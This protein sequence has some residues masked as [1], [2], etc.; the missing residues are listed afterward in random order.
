MVILMNEYHR[1]E[2]EMLRE[3]AKGGDGRLEEI[4]RRLS[5]PPQSAY[6]GAALLQQKGLAVLRDT[7]RTRYVLTPRG[8]EALRDGLPEELLVE[9]ICR[10]GE[11]PIGEAIEALGRDLATIAVGQAK[12]QGLLKIQNGILT[13]TE[14]GEE[15]RRERPLRSQLD[16][17][18][19]GGEPRTAE[20]LLKRGLIERSLVTERLASL[21]PEGI[22]AS[23]R[24]VMDDR[25]VDLDPETLRTGAW[26]ER[27]FKPFDVKAPAPAARVAKKQPYRRFLDM[28]RRKLV[29]MGFMEMTGPLVELAFWNF[30][31]LFQAQ[32]HP[33]REIHDTFRIRNPSHGSLPRAGFVEKV[34]MTHEDGWTTGSTGWRYRWSRREASRLVGRTQ[35][36]ALSARTLAGG[37]D[38]P[39]KYFSIARVFRPDVLDRNHLIEFNQCEGIIADEGLTFRH[40]LGILEMF[41]VEI[42][43]ESK[44]AF[45]PSY[46]PF[47]EPSVDLVAYS[48]KQGQWVELAGAGIFRDEVTKPFGVDIPVIAWGVGIDR[49]AMFSLGV[50]DIRELFSHNLE[51]LRR[52]SVAI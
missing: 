43:R 35:G 29:S 51:W 9:R 2:V 25:I 15:V 3:L 23:S 17:V 14:R 1:L 37:I 16:E 52:A 5:I 47:T 7:T 13:P 18:R 38:P 34:R 6:Q 27:G 39:A 10:T 49:L 19:R 45:V 42:A 32:N 8:E 36:T 24:I 33:A 46:Y 20:I 12:A 28:T 41:A 30:D 4:A 40:L 26:K 48:E 21:T 44:Y 31:A 50:D 11:L 22:A